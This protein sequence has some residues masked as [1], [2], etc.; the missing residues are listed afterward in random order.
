MCMLTCAAYH[1]DILRYSFPKMERLAQVEEVELREMG[2]GYR[3]A[4]VTRTAKY[5]SVNIDD[6]ST[7]FFVNSKGH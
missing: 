3:A 1:N 7:S 4:F 6:S 2:F 5:V